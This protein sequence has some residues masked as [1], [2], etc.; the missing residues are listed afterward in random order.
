MIGVDVGGGRQ[1]AADDRTQPLVLVARKHVGRNAADKFGVARGG[2]PAGIGGQIGFGFEPE[3]DV[4]VVGVGIDRQADPVAGAGGPRNFVAVGVDLSRNGDQVGVA[5]GREPGTDRVIGQAGQ[6]H[7]SV[8]TADDLQ[9]PADA[10]ADVQRTP[11]GDQ[12]A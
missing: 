12:F 2:V 9:R 7:R 6:N 8:L 5:I 3:P 11:G 1:R 10:V 4:G